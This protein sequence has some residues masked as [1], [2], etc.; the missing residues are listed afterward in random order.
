M[1]LE[2]IKD[3]T[4]I[5]DCN[6]LKKSIELSLRMFNKTEES[7]RI[8]AGRLNPEFYENLS[9]RQSLDNV[10]DR[11]IAV[12]IIAGPEILGKPSKKWEVYKT[13]CREENHFIVVD[14]KHVKLDDYHSNNSEP[15]QRNVAFYTPHFGKEL[16]T[17]FSKLKDKIK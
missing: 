1:I 16:Y 9:I 8:I 12:E 7:I 14:R 3:R 15:G 13:P 17:Y 10:I 4:I 6:S 2:A 11:G 5:Y